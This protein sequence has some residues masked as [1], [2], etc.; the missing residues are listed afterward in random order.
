MTQSLR[1]LLL[2]GKYSRRERRERR[3]IGKARSGDTRV[4]VAN[5][6]SSRVSLEGRSKEGSTNVL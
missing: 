5:V 4:Q 2:S 1:R 3:S 6:A